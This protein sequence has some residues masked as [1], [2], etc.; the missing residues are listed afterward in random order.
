MNELILEMLGVKS[1]DFYHANT[2]ILRDKGKAFGA[3]QQKD[4]KTVLRVG[5]DLPDKGYSINV[6]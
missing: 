4:G 3:L 2:I 6:N 5:T 1:E